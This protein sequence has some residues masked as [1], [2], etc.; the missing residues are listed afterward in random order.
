MFLGSALRATTPKRLL[1]LLL[2]GLLYD[3]FLAVILG[4]TPRTSS[5]IDIVRLHQLRSSH[6]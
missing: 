3:Y 5:C 2:G 6:N 1:H 4:T